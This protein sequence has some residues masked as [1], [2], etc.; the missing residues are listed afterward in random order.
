[1]ILLT[2]RRGSYR[3]T[4]LKL[5][6]LPAKWSCCAPEL[7]PRVLSKSAAA[8][9]REVSM[10]SSRANDPSSKAKSFRQG[11]TKPLVVPFPEQL[12]KVYSSEWERPM[13]T[14]HKSRF[15]DKHILPE[16]FMNKIRVPVVDCPVVSLCSPPYFHLKGR[17][18]LRR[19]ATLRPHPKSSELQ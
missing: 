10:T 9:D 14:R 13:S 6:L 17:E 18:V 1:M 15:L 5:F 11:S 12:E 19:A 3:E 4:I 7:Y 16:S 2:R 8:M